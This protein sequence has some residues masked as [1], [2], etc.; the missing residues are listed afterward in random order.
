MPDFEKLLADPDFMNWYHESLDNGVSTQTRRSHTLVDQT[1]C[2]LQHLDRVS[3]TPSNLC[4]SNN[5]FAGTS[6]C[7][8]PSLIWDTLERLTKT[9]HSFDD[10]DF[11]G[12]ANVRLS[13]SVRR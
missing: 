8:D 6:D 9:Q 3:F 7:I 5:T 4:T 10:D 13:V 11:M 2:H 1:A 12:G